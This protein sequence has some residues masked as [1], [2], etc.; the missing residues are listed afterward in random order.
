VGISVSNQPSDIIDVAAI[1]RDFPV[2]HQDVFPGVPLVYLDN[3]ATAQKPLSVIEAVRHY[4]LA[5]NANIHR[6]IHALA[7]RATA[8]YE[9]ARLKIANF[10]GAAS[11]SE[12]IFVRNTT[13]AINLVTH[14]WGRVNIRVGDEILLTE[15]EHH[16]NLVPWQMLAQE[17]GAVI[18]YVPVNGDCCL[19]LNRYDALLTERTKVVALTGMSNVLGAITP[20]K[21]MIDKAH[22]AGAVVLVDGAQSV[23]HL[24]TA[25]QT[26]DVDFLAFSG[27]KMCG[28]TGIGVLYGKRTLLEAMPPFLGGGDMI[29]RVTLDGAEWNDLPWKFEAGTPSIAQAIGLGAAVDYLETVGMDKIEAYE[30]AIAEYALEAMSEVKGVSTLGPSAAERGAVIAF[31]VDGMHPHDIAELLNRD[32]VAVRA[33]HHCAMPLH[34]KLGLP[35]TSRASFYLYNTFDE[36]DRLVAALRRAQKVFGLA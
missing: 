4:Y 7:E 11:S 26:L 3:A 23:P 28:P 1:R 14:S 8:D 33:G 30:H 34:Q 5:D 25:V 18:R 27:H 15:L 10:I 24:P 17:R 6:G 13:E 9:K 35:A 32:G 2:L 21:E 22:R 31:T 19:D 29:R 36:A 16:S 20:A 12:I